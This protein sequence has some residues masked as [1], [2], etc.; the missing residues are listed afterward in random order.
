MGIQNNIMIF[1]EALDEESKKTFNSL[2]KQHRLKKYEP[3][4]SQ[5]NKERYRNF[6]KTARWREKWG[7]QK[8]V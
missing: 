5:K 8:I 2:L 6:K 7:R 3:K 1:S 4:N